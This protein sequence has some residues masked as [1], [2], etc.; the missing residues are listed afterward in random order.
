M[1]ADP[2]MNYAYVGRKIR[3]ALRT[4]RIKIKQGIPDRRESAP[5][6]RPVNDRILLFGGVHIRYVLRIINASQ[7]GSHAS[8]LTFLFYN[9]PD[10]ASFTHS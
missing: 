10:I 7:G 5:A 1:V 2:I 9:S 6:D 8:K 3:R 4:V